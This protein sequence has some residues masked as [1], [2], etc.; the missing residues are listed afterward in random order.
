MS[1]SCPEYSADEL[2]LA[3]HGDDLYSAKVLKVEQFDGSWQYFVH[4]IGWNKKWDEWVDSRRIVR[5]APENLKGSRSRKAR[6]SRSEEQEAKK[7]KKG[8]AGK[9]GQEAKKEKQ[10]AD[11]AKEVQDASKVCHEFRIPVPA[12]LRRFLVV[13][14]ENIV[15]LKQLVPLPRDPAVSQILENYIQAN[16]R[17]VKAEKVEPK[18]LR[19]FVSSLKAYFERILPQR[20]L[21]ASERLQ[22]DEILGKN[23]DK[24]AADLYGPEHLLRLFVIL[25]SMLFRTD[26]DEEQ[27]D[28]LKARLADFLRYIQKN[29]GMFVTTYQSFDEK[30]QQR[31]S[32]RYGFESAEGN[33]AEEQQVEESDV[34]MS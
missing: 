33:E 34:P 1:V 17:A 15:H 19:A 10:E 18:I 27:A 31:T 4:Y 6:V 8:H 23:P 11:I 13:D 12:N 24:T 20:L 25:P 16:S 28:V 32:D 22:Y 30:Y 14:W 21:Y 26:I 5:D 29:S 7:Q 2:V 9:R 3:Y